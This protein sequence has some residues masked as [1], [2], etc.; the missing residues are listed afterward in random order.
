MRVAHRVSEEHLVNVD[1]FLLEQP[2]VSLGHRLEAVFETGNGVV[3]TEGRDGR[4][5]AVLDVPC[6]TMPSKSHLCCVVCVCVC[7]CLKIET[8][9]HSVCMLS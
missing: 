5:A 4:T 7:V 6:Y 9:L 2:V 8:N 3:V 1:L